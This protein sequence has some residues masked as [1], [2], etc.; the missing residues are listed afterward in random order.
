[1]NISLLKLLY[2]LITKVKFILSYISNGWVI[3]SVV[4]TSMV[5]NSELNVFKGIKFV[6]AVST[7]S[8]NCIFGTYVY[9][10]LESCV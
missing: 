4:H 6:G 3:W 7:K 2:Y 1:M 8:P 10:T 9:K 5:W